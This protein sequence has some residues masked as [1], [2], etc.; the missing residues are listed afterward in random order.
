MVSDLSERFE[1][2]CHYLCIH[3]VDMANDVG[4]YL[5]VPQGD[6]SYTFRCRAAENRKTVLAYTGGASEAPKTDIRC[7]W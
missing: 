2:W 1:D 7:N 3:P 6:L 5:Q 4:K